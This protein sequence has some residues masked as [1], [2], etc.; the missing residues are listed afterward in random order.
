MNALKVSRTAIAFAVL[1]TAFSILYFKFVSPTKIA[2]VN[3]Q[4]FQYTIY[5]QVNNNPF[6][7]VEHI[8]LNSGKIPNFS[9]YDAVYFFS[10]GLHLTPQ[11]RDAVFEAN[12]NK[13]ALYVYGS[14]TTEQGLGNLPPQIATV[15]EHYFGYGGSVN[16]RRMLNYTRKILDNKNLFTSDLEPPFRIPTE[17]YFHLGDEE[18]FESA[19]E[20]QK[21]YEDKGFY[22]PDAPRVL[23][24]CSNLGPHTPTTI[25]PI[26]SLITQ[27]QDDGMNVYPVTG[28]FKRLERLQEISPDCVVFVAHGRLAPGNP[29]ES[30]ELLKKLNVPLLC[31]VILFE[32]Y[33]EWIEGQKGMAGGMFAQNIVVPEIDGG[34][35]P[36]LI[37]AK[38]E[39][40]N[41]LMSFGE[42]PG[43]IQKFSRYTRN[44]INLKKT[45]TSKKK[46]AIVYYKGPGKNSLSA[47]GLDVVSSLY[48]LL[49]FLKSIGYTTGE[50]PGSRQAFYERIQKEGLVI[51]S[52]AKGATQKFCEEGNPERVSA[53]DLQKWMSEEFPPELVDVLVGEYGEVPGTYLNGVDTAGNKFVAIPR[54]VFGN[55][56]IVPQ[57]NPGTA[58]KTYSQFRAIKYPP[59]YP[60]IASYLWIRKGF[61]AD[62]LIHFGTYGS[63]EFLPFKQPPLSQFDWPDALLGTLPHFYLYCVESVGDALVA[64]RRGYATILSHLTPPFRKSGVYGTLRQLKGKLDA[65]YSAPSPVLREQY[66]STVFDLVTSSGIDGDLAIELPSVAALTD[67]SIGRIADYVGEIAEEK[68]HEGLYTLGEQY[69]PKQL[70]TTCE[71]MFGDMLSYRL[72]AI[73]IANGVVSAGIFDNAPM[74][75]KRYSKKARKIINELIQKQKSPSEYL[76]LKELI[77]LKK[78]HQASTSDVVGVDLGE[79]IDSYLKALHQITPAYE[80]LLSSNKSEHAA[81]A[82]VLKGGYVEPSSG[83]DPIANPDVVPTG[84]NLFGINPEKT[85]DEEAWRIGKRIGDQLLNGHLAKTGAYPRK[86]AFT[87]W[88]GEFVR[89]RGITVAQ[90]LYLLGIKPV[91]NKMGMVNDLEL[92]PCSELGHPRIDVVMQTSG[93]FRDLAASRIKLLQKAVRLAAEA[94]DGPD[95][96]NYVQTGTVDMEEFMKKK[97][98][99][100]QEARE[101]STTRIFGGKNGRYGAGIREMVQSGDQWTESDQ[102]AGQYLSFMGAAY[103]DTHWD[104]YK[105]GLFEAALQNTEI[106]TQSV[107]SHITGP[108]ALDNVYEFMGG[109][110]SVV[111]MLTGKKPET[112]FADLRNRFMPRVRDAREMV[113]TEARARLLNPSFIKPMLEGSSSSY[114]SV[115]ETFRNCFG[116][117][118]LDS[119]IVN[120]SMWEQIHKTYIQDE[121]N[122]GI[123]DSFSKRNPYAF[124]EMTA[125]MLESARKGFWS[126]SP[127]VLRNLSRIHATL[128]KEHKAGCSIHVCNNATL[129]NLIQQNLKGDLRD[130]YNAGINEILNERA[131]SSDDATILSKVNQKS[132]RRFIEENANALLIIGIIISIFI[133]AV[134]LGNIRQRKE[135]G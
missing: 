124:Q 68:I 75:R 36:F 50:L 106:I 110:S 43:R 94:N 102:I 66:R 92:I 5:H 126:P 39:Q 34:I 114:E 116:W 40:K 35:M 4:D 100:P 19:K 3:F 77:A 91:N 61:H 9:N 15:M 105:E 130:S 25:A 22:K 125:V 127:N 122:L 64:K 133:A 82:N 80:A 53:D 42:V 17:A 97:G 95:C 45:D 38:Y 109:L 107:N 11:Q 46:V 132:L 16:A 7:K 55:I 37:G 60:Y 62:A 135:Q 118:A 123:I 24:L 121:H 117:N 85:P 131:V 87:L 79:S 78:F 10:M 104:Y 119:G 47:T 8:D 21:F 86:V 65:F 30:I 23:L 73:D 41:G 71:E 70:I 63:F 112:V 32:P 89:D 103:G 33:D 52:Y 54:I 93:Q 128:V 44:Y 12:V 99:S 6:I 14:S 81:I 129:R 48:N 72:A 29:D 76:N 49:K 31:P 57:L 28:F 67:H 58:D 69:S 18:F 90:I 111:R 84:K 134:L 113:R 74:F 98:F 88:G 115:A 26:R 13:T 83:G 1:L 101:L 96:T 56:T 59:P 108:L 27:L 120:S 51:G 2:F 20:Y